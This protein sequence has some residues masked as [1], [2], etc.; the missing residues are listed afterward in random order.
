[1]LGTPNPHTLVEQTPVSQENTALASVEAKELPATELPKAIIEDV[2]P[3]CAPKDASTERI[4]DICYRHLEIKKSLQQVVR[5]VD[6]LGALLAETGFI[7]SEEALFDPVKHS[8][9]DYP[10]AKES[11]SVGGKL[12]PR[13]SRGGKHFQRHFI[14]RKPN[15][16]LKVLEPYGLESIESL[17]N[18]ELRNATLKCLSADGVNEAGYI[19]KRILR[20]LV[21]GDDAILQIRDHRL[22]NYAAY[23]AVD[24]LEN[25]SPELQIII[26]MNRLNVQ[27]SRAFLESFQRH[28]DAA[29]LSIS[30]HVVPENRDLDLGSLASSVPNKPSVFICTPKTMARL[31]TE[32]VIEPKAVQAMIVYEAEYVL[33]TPS[34]METISSAL[35]T[36][37][38]CQVVLAAHDGDEGLLL[39]AKLFSFTDE[40]IVF[41]MDHA[42]IHSAE[43]YYYTEDSMT[44]LVLDRAVDLSKE[45]IVVVICRDATAVNKLKDQLAPRTD[46]LTI[47]KVVETNGVINGLHLTP[48]IVSSVLHNRLHTDVKM[49]LNLSETFLTPQRYLEMMASYMET[50]KRCAIISKVGSLVGL[51]GIEDIGIPLRKLD[52]NLD[53]V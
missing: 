22:Q 31:R 53:L 29:E 32:N 20:K 19:E 35:D 48:Q 34:N 43:H 25:A 7:S 37:E 14:Q 46:V 8:V 12:R 38:S 41:S 13:G 49:I 30:L 11:L 52:T 42:N 44:E 15:W 40:R 27:S 10:G 18:M 23:V 47:S 1:M 51:K 26:L 50:D 21:S 4:K 6:R 5:H 3:G 16:T 9:V 24:V 39:A 36:F 45:N 2:D 17:D 33:R 28:I